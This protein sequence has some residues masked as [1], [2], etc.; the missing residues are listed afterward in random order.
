MMDRNRTKTAKPAGTHQYARTAC[1]VRALQL[2]K[3]RA[4][5]AEPGFCDTSSSAF[6]RLARESFN[7]CGL[8]AF[9]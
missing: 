2:P 3:L 8:C 1:E 7:K 4:L 9:S 6:G 5:V